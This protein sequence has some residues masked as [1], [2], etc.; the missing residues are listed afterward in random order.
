MNKP[1]GTQPLRVAARL[2]PAARWLLALF[3]AVAG[4]FH[5]TTPEPFLQIMPGFVPMPEAVVRVTGW[6]ELA[7]A[8]ALVQPLSRRLRIAGGWGLALYALAVWPANFNHFALDMAR[9]EG[10]LGL[11]YHLPRLLAQPLLMWLTLWAAEAVE[12]PF[13]RGRS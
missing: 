5:L 6:A 4:W 1:G 11:T 12:W 10:G 8:A 7:G 3:Y 2:R 13:G 9:A